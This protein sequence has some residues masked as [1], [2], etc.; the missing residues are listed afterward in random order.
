M[1]LLSH[2]E[3]RFEVREMGIIFVLVYT[4]NLL[5]H[6]KTRHHAKAGAIS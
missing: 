5:Q 1:F 3:F 2:M 6:G 4:S